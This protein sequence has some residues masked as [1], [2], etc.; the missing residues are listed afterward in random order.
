MT[1]GIAGAFEDE[2]WVVVDNLLSSTESRWRTRRLYTG[3]INGED[4]VVMITGLG[5][6]NTATSIQYLLNHYPVEKVI[7]AGVAGAVNPKVKI[8]DIVISRNAVQ[9]DFDIG[10]KGIVEKMRTPRFGADPDLIEM[11]LNACHDLGWEENVRVGTVLT[12]DQAIIESDKKRRLWEAF[13]GDCVEM[14]GAAA[15]SVCSYNGVP[16]VLIRSITDN[17]DETAREDCLRTRA[18]ACQDAARVVLG[19][20]GIRK[21]D[22]VRQRNFCCRL[23]RQL[24]Q[25]VKAWRCLRRK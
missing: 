13:Q 19:M 3:K 16:F 9:H 21:G 17:A 1:W 10:G 7:F 24:F 14:E 25:T 4:I 18:R 23:K 22:D 12:G 2:V 6:V 15:A 11:A 8:G 20:L 5:K